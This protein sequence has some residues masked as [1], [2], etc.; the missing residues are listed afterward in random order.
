MEVEPPN[1]G[2]GTGEPGPDRSFRLAVAW[3]F[4]FSAAFIA[5]GTTVVDGRLY[6]SLFDD[7]MISMRYARNLAEG[8]GLVWNPG[9][10]GVEG[11][12]NFAW[13]LV[14]AL[15]HRLGVPP[16]LVGIV[17]AALSALALVATLF[18]VRDL[19]RR[20]SGD[21]TVARVAVW[22]TAL[23]Y[24]LSY[25]ALRGMETGVLALTFALCARSTVRICKG[26]ARQVAALAAWSAVAVLI[27]TDSLVP[28]AACGLAILWAGPPGRRLRPVVVV[29]AVA[30]ATFAAH[31]LLRIAW[32]GEPLPN[33]YHLKV[34]GIPLV[35]RVQRGSLGL[36]V[37]TFTGWWLPLGLAFAPFLLRLQRIRSIASIPLVLISSVGAYSAWTGG[38]AWEWMPYPN[39]FLTR[40]IPL[41]AVSSA[42]GVVAIARSDPRTRRTIGTSCVAAATVALVVLRVEVLPTELLQVS[43][44]TF[45]ARSLG[46]IVTVL[47]CSAAALVLRRGGPRAA[48]AVLCTAAVL[49]TSWVGL[50]NWARSD[51]ALARADKDLVEIGV[52]VDEL[53]PP[54]TRIGVVAAGALPYF[55]DREAIDLLGKSD[56]T[57]AH[58]SPS[59]TPHIWPGHDKWDHVHSLDLEPDLVFGSWGGMRTHLEDRG[60][61]RVPVEDGLPSYAPMWVAPWFEEEAAPLVE[62]LEERY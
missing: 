35:E 37:R 41:V 24:P 39:R 43:T 46:M 21:E 32:Y 51:A 5:Q 61:R 19:A 12:T 33:T 28:V 57:I 10:P 9:E 56:A 40:A 54:D 26:E 49:A 30:A 34:A 6:G 8:R 48:T 16:S 31:T 53:T 2:S 59:R 1:G 13:T 20:I 60:Y 44:L 55:A 62:E 11:Y 47:V 22:I 18:V 50:T 38:D 25:W 15:V 58:E 14:M 36:V 4:A 7:S 3:T 27:R 17:V 23:S 42:L 45:P 29:G 52:L